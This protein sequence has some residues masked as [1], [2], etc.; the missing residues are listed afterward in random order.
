MPIAAA[1]RLSIPDVILLTPRRFPDARGF[2]AV[3]Y[4]KREYQEAGIDQTFIQDNHSL[5]ADTGTLRG[6]HY[7]SPPHTQAKLVRVVRGRI[8]DVAVDARPS[9]PHYG[10]WVSAEISAEE[11]N[12]ILV[13]QGFLHGFV[14]LEPNT[15]V[16]YKVDAE[17][18]GTADGSVRW[19]DPDI[20]IEWGL[21]DRPPVLSDKDANAPSWRDWDN[22]FA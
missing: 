6:L 21:G 3:T 22:P 5:S 9:S 17:Y 19:D 20:G 1:T 2:F 12:Q 18:D 7:Q 14:T 8:L 16:L 4:N 10:K 15:E 13:P 11:G